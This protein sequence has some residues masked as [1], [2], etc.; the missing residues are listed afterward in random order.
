VHAW[1][2]AFLDRLAATRPATPALVS[3]R[4]ERSVHTLLAEIRHTNRLRLLLDYDGTLVP[5]ARSP[6]LAAPDPELLQLLNE[7][8]RA[9]DIVL[10]IVSGRPCTTLAAW[11]GELPA[12]LWAEHGFWHRRSP[13]DVWRPAA[14]I[15]PEWTARILQILRQFT[16]NT[17]GS[18]IEIKPAAIAWHFR[19]AQRE[20]GSR[21]GHELRML[22]GEVLSNQPFEV[23]EGRKVIE[24]RLRG[25]SKAAVA[26]HVLATASA[27]TTLIA[28]GDDRTDEELFRALPRSSFT[29][30]VGEHTTCA[31]FRVDDYRA[32]RQ[33]LRS[34]V[35]GAAPKAR[36]APLSSIDDVA[37]A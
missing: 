16:A 7:L 20:F 37:L 8:V 6:E 1:A 11:L 2:A 28:I 13:Q 4:P 33:L 18:R 10:E 24:V 19:G 31:R 29:I 27:D 36:P 35:A 14:R 3:L 21:Q 30:A 34:L 5:F 22:L 23:L 12:A 15:D 17:P 32:V 25:V 26:Q 9:S